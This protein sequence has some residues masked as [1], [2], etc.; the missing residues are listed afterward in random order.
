MSGI[1][2]VISRNI[3]GPEFLGNIEAHAHLVFDSV[4]NLVVLAVSGYR[5]RSFLGRG[6]ALV[7]PVWHVGRAPPRNA[8]REGCRGRGKRENGRKRIGKAGKGD[9]RMNREAREG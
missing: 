2:S 9:E 4:D 7:S 6:S 3:V 1:N 8:V 5:S